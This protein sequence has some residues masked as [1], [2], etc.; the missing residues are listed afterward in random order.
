MIDSDSFSGYAAALAT[1]DADLLAA[2]L[3]VARIRKF[4]RR[5]AA[6]TALEK[7]PS[8]DGDSYVAARTYHSHETGH[9]RP[10]MQRLL[11]YVALFEIPLDYLLFGVDA[12]RYEAEARDLAKRA[13]TSLKIDKFTTPSDQ[14]ALTL[15]KNLEDD[16]KIN[17]DPINQLSQQSESKASHNPDTRF[18][19]ILTASEIRKLST[20]K[21][22]LA[23]MS[24]PMLPVPDFLNASR[25]AFAYRIPVDD[26]SMVGPGG[27]SFNAGGICMIDPEAPI[28]PGKYALAIIKGEP[29]PVVRQYVASGP[30]APGRTFELHALNPAFRP[31]IVANKSACLFIARVISFVTLL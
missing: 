22:D 13:G 25:H 16:S 30:Y 2:R 31:I 12:E 24:G 7:M 29:E 11:V 21:G 17:A 3:E 19:V 5:A 1:I 9:R 10:K 8:P 26:N 18:I 23:A 14:R 28:P 15:V 27:L 20:G 4:D 6:I